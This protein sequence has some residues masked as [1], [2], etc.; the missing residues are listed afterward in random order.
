MEKLK[1]PEVF[2][3]KHILRLCII[4]FIGVVLLVLG[5]NGTKK[6]QAPTEQA[7]PTQQP[8]AETERRLEAILS[9]IKG[10]GAVDVMITY[11][12]TGTRA[13][14]TEVSREQTRE[15]SRTSTSESTSVVLPDDAPVLEEEVYP[16][17]RGVIAVCEGAGSASVR[18]QVILALRAVLNVE[19]HRI[20]VFAK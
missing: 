13:Y 3:N 8:Y 19:E 17:V 18:E 15:E 11:E 6:T 7:M 2:K 16:K 9:K 10:V 14:V 20:G 4:L 5:G 12:G 1:L